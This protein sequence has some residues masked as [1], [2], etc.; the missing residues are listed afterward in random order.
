MRLR[1]PLSEAAQLRIWY[2]RDAWRDGGTF[3]GVRPAG[4]VR[5]RRPFA[6][7]GRPHRR[8]GR[9]P[10]PQPGSRLSRRARLRPSARSRP[11]RSRRAGARRRSRPRADRSGRSRRRGPRPVDVD[12]PPAQEVPC[13]ESVVE[14]VE[15]P[16][17]PAVVGRAR[18]GG[19]GRR[20]SA[21]ARARRRRWSRASRLRPSRPPAA[22]S[23]VWFTFSPM[24]STTAPLA[25]SARTP[26]TL[27]RLSMT[28][29]GH[30][31]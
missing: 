13:A 18:A 14:R 23:R 4:D 22:R 27:R 17:A 15:T 20:G 24:P 7:P 28:S 6:R 19:E 16:V 11:R 3:E 10:E 8:H 1:F 9:G 21:R 2:G 25:A 29:F 31:I 30:L 26:A 5:I 12:A